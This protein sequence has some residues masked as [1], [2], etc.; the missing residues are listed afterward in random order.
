VSAIRSLGL[1]VGLGIVAAR[2]AAFDVEELAQLSPDLGHEARV[3]IRKQGE[4]K[5]MKTNNMVN[6]LPRNDGRVISGTA[7]T[8]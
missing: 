8:K 6:E 4:R 7:F 1:A 5:A 3:S 2:S